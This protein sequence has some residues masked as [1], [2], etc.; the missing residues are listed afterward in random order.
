MSSKPKPP[1]TTRVA[2]KPKA[3]SSK[4]LTMKVRLPPSPLPLI[5]LTDSPLQFM[6]RS[7][8]SSRTETLAV[9]EALTQENAKRDAAL[10]ARERSASTA[11]AETRWELSYVKKIDAKAGAGVVDWGY[12]QLVNSEEEDEED[13][14]EEQRVGGGGR[15]VFGGFKSQAEVSSALTLIGRHN[16]DAG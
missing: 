11:D 2:A 6:Q 12:G 9:R 16:A 8:A 14:D 15:M 13:E 10:Q 3:M 1:A 4:L 7:A 5:T